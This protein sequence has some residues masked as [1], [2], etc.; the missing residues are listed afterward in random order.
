MQLLTLRQNRVLQ[1]PG[2]MRS[3]LLLASV[4]GLSLAA[5]QVGSAPNT[6]AASPS[7]L[8]YQRGYDV[9]SGWLCYEWNNGVY[10]CMHYWHGSANGTLI[11]NHTSPVPNVG[12]TVR[13]RMPA[14][15]TPAHTPRHTPTPTPPPL[16]PASGSVVEEIQSAFGSYASAALAI[17]ACES[18]YNPSAYNRS[19]GASGVFQFLPN[20]WAGTSYAGYSPFNAWANI[21]AAYQVFQRD[22]YSWREWQCQP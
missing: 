6:H 14:P 4:L 12:A 19:S 13:M 22:G 10:H 21:H 5:A 1:S 3:G 9:D 18:G 7:S 11:S 16:H 8:Y 2:L 17:A 15:H 20:M